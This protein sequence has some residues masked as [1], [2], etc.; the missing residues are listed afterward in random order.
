MNSLTILSLMLSAATAMNPT[1]IC[2]STS[3]AVLGG[4]VTLTCEFPYELQVV[5]VTWQKKTNTVPQTMVTSTKEY[6]LHIAEP[7]KDIV[8][9]LRTDTTRSSIAIS[10][11]VKEDE[12]CY[13][14]IFVTF[15]DGAYTG[16]VCLTN[17]VPSNEVTCLGKGKHLNIIMTP[18]EII[19]RQSAQGIKSNTEEPSVQKGIYID[20]SIHP[21][22]TFHLQGTRRKNRSLQGN[23]KKSSE[24]WDDVIITQCSASG[25]QRTVITWDNEENVISRE[26]KENT[27][28]NITTVTSTI[29]LSVSS[30][31]TNF[32]I[33]CNITHEG[34]IYFSTAQVRSW[35]EIA[36]SFLPLIGWSIRKPP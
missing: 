36:Q 17:L 32:S 31:S 13:N 14:C 22:C 24:G 4:N 7:F 33:T 15:P 18:T 3:P 21:A 25:R 26:D 8:S 20:G 35:R 27:T 5:Q 1:V 10:K 34:N 16:E 9:V 2:T 30:L 19:P 29:H 12:A 28:G 6:G 11:L 23:H